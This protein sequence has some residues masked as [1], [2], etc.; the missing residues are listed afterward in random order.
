MKSY[1]TIQALLSLAASMMI[2]VPA[3]NAAVEDISGTSFTLSAD[4]GYVSVADGGS[5][6]SW[7]YSIDGSPM[8]LPGPTLR[9]TEGD[10]VTVTLNNDLPLAAGNV[11]IVFNGQQVSA[12][13]GVDGALT[14]EAP[15]NGS[16]TYSFLAGKP[17]TY[18][19]HSGTRSDLQVE[20]GL[21]GVL[22]VDPAAAPADIGCAA[23]VHTD[24]LESGAAYDHP[25]SCYDREYLFV[26][27]SIDLQVHTAVEA[28]AAGPGPIVL[29]DDAFDSSEYWLLNGRV[30]PDTMAPNFAQN[31]DHQPY[32][33]L[34]RMHPG[35][36]V[37]VRTVGGG[38][39]FHP[40]HLHGNHARVI[41]RDGNMLLTGLGNLAGPLLFT[42]ASI[43]GTTTDAIWEWTGK[44]LNWD[45]YGHLAGSGVACVDMDDDGFNDSDGDPGP[46]DNTHEY[47][48]D[49]E[50]EMPVT[51]PSFNNLAFGGF[52]SG[53]PFLGDLG[54]LPPGE[55]GL[56]PGAGF[57]FMWHSHTERELVNNDVFPGGLMT[58]MIVEAP[59][60][61]IVE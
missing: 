37:L 40:F 27:S 13:G 41:A 15:V 19:Y 54:S 42:I 47:C 18:Q 50:K 23:P 25:G 9:V 56:N 29:P 34:A 26:T 7:G 6:Y 44:D 28:Q 3:A 53:S 60:V 58:M 10:T 16:V 24:A 55:G 31:L 2:A 59:N 43:P 5:I 39:E 57:A 30:G 20:M 32:G 35:E 45:M 49:H 61:E 8:Q 1:K 51:L 33:A 38:R 17:G 22:I 21:F 12:T 52:Y 11:S 14:R 4:D 48:A 36:K 46:G